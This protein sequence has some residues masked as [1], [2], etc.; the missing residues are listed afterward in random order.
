MQSRLTLYVT[1]GTN[2][3]LAVGSYAGSSTGSYQLSISPY[4]WYPISATLSSAVLYPEL[5]VV[6]TGAGGAGGA[7]GAFAAS[8]LTNDP[9]F[10]PVSRPLPSPQPS[11]LPG[12]RLGELW[13]AED[14]GSLLAHAGQERGPGAA[15]LERLFTALG[16]EPA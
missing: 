11:P 12:R 4:F 6:G 9:L 16:H 5:A 15:V 14:L 7:G 3:K 8:V 10:A 2:Y 1:A 13:L